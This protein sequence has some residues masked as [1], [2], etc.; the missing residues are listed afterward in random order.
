MFIKIAINYLKIYSLINS[1]SI[2]SVCDCVEFLSI[3]LIAKLLCF[4]VINNIPKFVNEFFH[5][6]FHSQTPKK[7]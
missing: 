7:N 3:K 5:F 1:V 2:N 6:K 4:Q